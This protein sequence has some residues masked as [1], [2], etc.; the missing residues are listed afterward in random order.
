MTPNEPVISFIVVTYNSAEFVLETLNSAKE[1]NYPNIELII[2]DDHSSDNTVEICRHWISENNTHFKRTQIVTSEK[3]TGTSANLNRGLKASTGSWIKFI[4]GDDYLYPDC[5][6]VF[7]AEAK[8]NPEIKFLFANT[9]ANGKEAEDKKVTAFFAMNNKAQYRELLKNSI[10]PAPG[11]FICREVVEQLNGFD[12]K[13]KLLEDYPF[14]LKALKSGVRFFHINQPLV[15]YRVHE[16][17]ISLQQKI[18]LNYITD[19]KLF[20]KHFYL[21]ELL[22]NRLFLHFLH[23]TLQYFLL[24]LTTLRIIKNLK[25]YNSILKWFSL[26]NWKLRF[27]KRLTVNNEITL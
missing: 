27:Q 22:K 10:L 9:A 11:A 18:N 1:Q 19:V 2:T 5:F 25:T 17:N 16:T 7:I 6:R 20:F 23:Y 14:F 13:Y 8:S 26:L 21:N 12:E 15:Y 24:E 3:N 4:A